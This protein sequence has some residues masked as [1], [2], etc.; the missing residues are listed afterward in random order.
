M[1]SVLQAAIVYVLLWIVIRLT[2]R[3]ALGQ[4]ST[5][6][7]VLFLII[8]GT[9]QRA[10]LG[11][12]YSLTNAVIV[13]A[14]LVGLD[15]AVSLIEQR[16]TL[17]SKIVRGVP[18]ILVE[19]GRPLESRLTRARLSEADIMVAAR[20]RHGIDRIED[21]KFAILEANGHI[22]IV[23]REAPQVPIR[24]MRPPRPH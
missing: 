6:E 23:P 16:S 14:T 24:P 8:G 3:R 18:T 12:D 22:S 2:G 19:N 1:D 13:I 11:Q 7:F 5:F 15:V 4:L 20:L 10:L 9:V 21:I 17:F